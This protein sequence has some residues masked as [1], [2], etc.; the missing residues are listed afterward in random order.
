M[1]FNG[2]FGAHLYDFVIV[3]VGWNDETSGCNSQ[4]GYKMKI[5]RH[6]RAG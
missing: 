3:N 1:L 6:G 5:L 2:L 4:A